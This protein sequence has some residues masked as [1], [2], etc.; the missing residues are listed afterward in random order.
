MGFG[1]N[2]R[3][4]GPRILRS[5][6][7]CGMQGVGSDAT[8]RHSANRSAGVSVAASLIR[9][10]TGV[11]PTRPDHRGAGDQGTHPMRQVDQLLAGHAGKEVFV[12]AR[13]PDHLVREHRTNHDCHVRLRDVPVDPYVHGDV[14][15]QTTGQFGLT[16]R[17]ILQRRER[18][19]QPRLV[20]DNGPARIGLLGGARG[21][22]QMARQMGPHSS[23]GGFQER[24]PQ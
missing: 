5:A 10:R 12:A 17:S 20:I 24:R 3:A 19:R 2:L 22:T 8:T 4:R 18:L 7:G 16:L 14:A 9:A 15:H 11:T 6:E 21:V 23:L 13:K 1:C